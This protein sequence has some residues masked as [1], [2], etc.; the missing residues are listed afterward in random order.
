MIKLLLVNLISWLT[1]D[2]TSLIAEFFNIFI[3]KM[4]E[5]E[6]SVSTSTRHTADHILLRM[7]KYASNVLKSTTIGTKFNVNPLNPA[8]MDVKFDLGKMFNDQSMT[9]QKMKLIN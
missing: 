9:Y 3:E 6:E 4:N 5:S 8:S 7:K 1:S 2:K